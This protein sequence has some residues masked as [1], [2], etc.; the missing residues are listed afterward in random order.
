MTLLQ[1]RCELLSD[2]SR[3]AAIAIHEAGHA[4]AAVEWRGGCFFASI[5]PQKRVGISWDKYR[6]KK[7]YPVFALV[8]CSVITALCGPC[9][10]A[11]YEGRKLDLDEPRNSCDKADIIETLDLHEDIALKGEYALLSSFYDECKARAFE[12]V[13]EN[14]SAIQRIGAELLKWHTISGS[15]VENI[16]REEQAAQ[17]DA[18]Y[19]A[20]IEREKRQEQQERENWRSFL[21]DEE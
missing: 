5:D 15:S 1:A 19:R 17:R 21:R 14:W 11:K 8:R 13:E 20:A 7:N 9:A 10:A 4:T 16:M 3:M 2:Q 18:L 6:A 12:T